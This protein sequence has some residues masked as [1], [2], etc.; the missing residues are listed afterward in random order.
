MKR[1]AKVLMLLALGAVICLPGM[2]KASVSWQ[3]EPIMGYSASNVTGDVV[4]I[5]GPTPTQPG[6]GFYYDVDG[7]KVLGPTIPHYSISGDPL[8]GVGSPSVTQFYYNPNTLTGGHW[9]DTV[10]K[11]WSGSG[12]NLEASHTY[13]WTSKW[14]FLGTPGNLPYVLGGSPITYNG[15][16]A[17]IMTMP[18]LFDLW[19]EDAGNWQYTQTWTDNADSAFIT[20]TRDFTLVVPIPGTVLLLGSGLL[21]LVG[22]GRRV[23]KS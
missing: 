17:F 11:I 7:N 4:V 12:I 9:T 13:T 10:T 5:T 14:S 19:L 18:S 23:R 3:T 6:G 22:L 21:G 8:E 15:G 20:S 2:A 16:A 1:L